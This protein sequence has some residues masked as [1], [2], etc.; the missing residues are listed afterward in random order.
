MKVLLLNPPYIKNFCR[1][2]RWAAVSRGRV[3]RHPDRLLIATAVL[4][5]EG[6]ETL[7]L[8]GPVLGLSRDDVLERMKRFKPDLA[9]IHT[10]TPSIYN[11]IEYAGLAKEATGARTALVG[12]HPTAEIENTFEIAG[13]KVDAIALGEYDFTLPELADGAPLKDIKGIAW[14]EDGAT[15]VN[16]P[17]EPVD[18]E[19]LPFPAWHHIRPEDYYDGGKLHPFITLISARGC[20]GRCTFCRDTVSPTW[21][22]L[23]LRSAEAV[24]DEME[25]DIRLFPKLREIMFE[26]DTFVASPAHV[27]GICEQI[28]RR[29]LKIRWSCNCRVD[30]KRDLLPLMKRAGCRMLMT[31]F[32]FGTQAALDAVKKGVTLEDSLRFAEAA[33]RQKLIIHGCFMIGAPGETR[34]SARATIDF[35]KALPLDTIQ[36][37]GICTYPGTEL[38]GWAKR[39]GYLVPKDWTEWIGA[40]GEQVTLLS[41]PQLSKEEIDKLM[42]RGLKE[43]YLRPKQMLRMLL[44]I[45][46]IGDIKRKAF[47]FMKFLDYL[48]RTVA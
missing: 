2:A 37:S 36:I 1:S 26:T 12:P 33:H 4:E 48:C 34:E 45:R 47:G 18:V 14:K 8:D 23:R 42:D 40:D 7:F 16:D 15:H 5:R 10:T 17:R 44:N 13:D 41:Y 24:A 31:G 19:Q 43:F 38:Y 27:H 30:M 6:H 22:K 28:L 32:E 20:Y 25:Y 9:V 3:Q 21:K 39:N 46:S 35:A 11:D 29:N